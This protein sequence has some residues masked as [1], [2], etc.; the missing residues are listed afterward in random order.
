MIMMIAFN[1]I[2]LTLL[3]SIRFAMPNSGICKTL[4][5][6]ISVGRGDK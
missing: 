6:I 4:S 3:R 2:Y 5:V 1:K